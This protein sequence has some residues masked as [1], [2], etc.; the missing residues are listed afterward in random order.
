MDLPRLFKYAT[1][2]DSSFLDALAIVKANSSGKMWLTGS[3]LYRLLASHLYPQGMD[4]R[5]W[6]FSTPLDFLVET[7]V[8]LRLPEGWHRK[9]SLEDGYQRFFR[10]EASQPAFMIYPLAQ[11][12]VIRDE[13]TEPTIDHFLAGAPL[14]IQSIAFDLYQHRMLGEAGM[15]AL[16]EKTVGV[17]HPQQAERYAQR[18]GKTIEALIREKAE[19]LGFTPVLP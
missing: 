17:H 8:D 5:Y 13:R 9:S 16:Q 3:Y 15:R 12:Q 11:S 4:L 7:F 19:V 18:K 2:D 10:G 14:T 1:R 6:R